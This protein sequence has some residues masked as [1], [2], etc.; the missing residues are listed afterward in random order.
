MVRVVANGCSVQIHD[1]A[2]L[3]VPARVWQLS[4]GIATAVMS[5]ARPEIPPGA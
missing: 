1:W 5:L 2:C 3:R 4:P